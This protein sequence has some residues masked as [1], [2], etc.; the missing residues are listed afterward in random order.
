MSLIVNTFSVELPDQL[1]LAGVERPDADERGTLDATASATRRSRTPSPATPSAAASGI[2]CTL[3]VGE[4]SGRFRSPC[5]S[6]QST[7]AGAVRLRH[8]AERADRDRVV[9][10]EHERHESLSTRLVDEAPRRARRSA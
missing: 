8:P 9:A 1:A 3:P 2:P 7:R 5:A 6:I 10:A 4:V